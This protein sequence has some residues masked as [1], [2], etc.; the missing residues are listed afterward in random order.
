LLF[1]LSIDIFR[2]SLF[3]CIALT[4][5]LSLSLSLPGGDAVCLTGLDRLSSG[6]VHELLRLHPRRRP[7]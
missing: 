2:H 3:L 4:F 1:S 7:K 6:S 5:S